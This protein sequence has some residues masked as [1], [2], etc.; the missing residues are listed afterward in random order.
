MVS[1]FPLHMAHSYRRRWPPDDVYDY[2]YDYDTDSDDRYPE[3]SNR[4]IH[5]PEDNRAEQ[6]TLGRMSSW[7]Q[8]HASSHKTQLAATA[9]LSGAAVAG[10]IFGYQALKR[11]EAV[12]ELKESIP[13]VNEPHSIEKVGN[14]AGLARLYMEDK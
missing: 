9:V 2:D 1:Q 3:S 10:A 5:G 6:G 12:R 11:Q 14:T 4:N 8:Q 13:D 7:I